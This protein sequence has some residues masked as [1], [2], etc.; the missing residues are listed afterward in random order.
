MEFGVKQLCFFIG[1]LFSILVCGADVRKNPV[2]LKANRVLPESFTLT[3]NAQNGRFAGVSFERGAYLP[4][5]YLSETD[6]FIPALF[7]KQVYLPVHLL[8]P[9]VS[10]EF[11]L[12][13]SCTTLA[14]FVQSGLNQGRYILCS[15][16]HGF[17]SPIM[18][19]AGMC[20][21][22]QLDEGGRPL[23][24][25]FGSYAGHDDNL[26]KQ[27]AVVAEVNAVLYARFTEQLNALDEQI[28]KIVFDDEDPWS[29]L[30]HGEFTD[31]VNRL[32]VV[33]NCSRDILQKFVCFFK[34]WH[35]QVYM[36]MPGIGR[37]KPL[38]LRDDYA[39]LYCAYS[40]VMQ[41]QT[42][43][44]QAATNFLHYIATGG[45]ESLFPIVQESSTQEVT[46]FGQTDAALVAVT[47][48][49]EHQTI[50]GSEMPKEVQQLRDE[51]PVE[52]AQ[53]VGAT[54]KGTPSGR[55][56]K[57]A[58]D[59]ARMQLVDAVRK[60]Q[61]TTQQASVISEQAKVHEVTD[62]NSGITVQVGDRTFDFTLLPVLGE[63]ETDELDSVQ[64]RLVEV[65]QRLE[66]ARKLAIEKR[67]ARIVA[68]KKLLQKKLKDDVKALE[69]AK[70]LYSK[71]LA[72]W[73]E[74][75]AEEEKI[76]ATGTQEG[77]D[78]FEKRCKKIVR[79]FYMVF[80]TYRKINTAEISNSPQ[81][82]DKINQI[83]HRFAH[84]LRFFQRHA[85]VYAKAEDV[86]AALEGQESTTKQEDICLQ[87]DIVKVCINLFGK[88]VGTWFSDAE[89]KKIL[90][91][92]GRS[93]GKVPS[94]NH[95]LR[96]RKIVSALQKGGDSY[97]NMVGGK[98]YKKAL[99]DIAQQKPVE[100]DQLR[101]CEL[102]LCMFEIVHLLHKLLT[103]VVLPLG[104]QEQELGV[105]EDIAI[106]WRTVFKDHLI[107]HSFDAA[108]A[109]IIAQDNLAKPMDIERCN[110][111][112]L[113]QAQVSYLVEQNR[114]RFIEQSVFTPV[115]AAMEDG[116]LNTWSVEEMLKCLI[117]CESTFY[118]MQRNQTEVP[119]EIYCDILRMFIYLRN[120]TNSRF[121]DCLSRGIGTTSCHFLQHQALQERSDVAQSIS[122]QLFELFSVAN[123]FWVY[124]N[125]LLTWSDAEWKFQMDRLKRI[126][127]S[128]SEY[129]KSSG[130]S[131][132]TVIP[133][134][135]G[136][137]IILFLQPLLSSYAQ[138]NPETP[139][140]LRCHE[141]VQKWD[142]LFNL[143]DCRFFDMPEEARD[144]IRGGLTTVRA[145][146]VEYLARMSGAAAHT[147]HISDEQLGLVVA[148]T[149]AK[150]KAKAAQLALQEVQ[151]KTDENC[152]KK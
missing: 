115:V 85:M 138:K 73:N 8:A 109:K 75:L 11:G 62:I 148:E 20:P 14:Y 37:P 126:A 79:D 140:E 121:K 61:A 42:D 93:D 46:P 71:E 39:S 9:S 129:K 4:C 92:T 135:E 66:A 10:G 122:L 123:H 106:V 100:L 49:E 24:F 22:L 137:R 1:C 136:L 125:D 33:Q 130:C 108:I 116:S 29:R 84:E 119:E 101:S 151:P 132:H 114:A 54:K 23:Y 145:S 63:E 21:I 152:F 59:R 40:L 32:S 17:A 7:E 104:D 143:F 58:S 131:F 57:K 2:L 72:L 26:I 25:S 94:A 103:H 55:V 31:V 81:E 86:D 117:A 51:R 76:I 74:K 98:V 83:I 50:Q 44:G 77:K 38:E 28:R 15:L 68:R 27:A 47:K 65:Q 69:L 96:D 150:K 13:R 18:D 48:T 53:A 127:S 52:Q 149:V 43:V 19:E 107:T 102:S 88:K 12:V 82:K 56:R 41:P 141:F 35:D 45:R 60:Q 105:T 144:P 133:K 90:K 113:V 67:L 146:I 6:S 124:Q 128:L 87:G 134:V 36:Q 91:D 99:E 80:T 118:A 147:I 34:N 142:V 78:L 97:K 89:K 120:L 110:S 5:Q 70:K 112:V 139:Q 111:S 16:Q 64:D 95:L 3:F 30:I